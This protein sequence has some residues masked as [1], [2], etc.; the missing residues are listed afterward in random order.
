MM[1]LLILLVVITT[2]CRDRVLDGVLPPRD[3]SIDNTSGTLGIDGNSSPVADANTGAGGTGG[4]TGSG[5][6]GSNTDTGG[7]TGNGSN[8]DA[9]GSGGNTGSGGTG[10]VGIPWQWPNS[11]S[12][13][14]SDAWLPVHHE[15]VTGLA[16]KLLV[17][18]YNN[19][20]AQS[21]VFVY[22]LIDAIKAG[23]TYHGY[24]DP[25][26]YP[27]L[28]YSVDR[29]IDKSDL[30]APA[31]WTHKYSTLTPLS[32]SQTFDVGALFSSS[33][34]SVL[35]YRDTSN[36]GKLLDLCTLFERG[37]IHEVWIL[38]SSELTVGPYIRKQIYDANNVA[39]KGSFAS[40]LGVGCT[41]GVSCSVT[42]RV[43]VLDPTVGTV[44]CSLYNGATEIVDLRL[45]VPYLDRML[46]SFFNLD[47]DQRF[48]VKF[49]SWAD[50]CDPNGASCITYPSATE[51]TGSYSDGSTWR[52]SPLLQGCGTQDYP[53]NA[54]ARRD[55]TN[56]SQVASRCEHYGM[57]DGAS[58]A[59]TTDLYS[60]SKV[61]TLDSQYPG[62]GGG[63][64]VYW[65]QNLP[66]L[67]NATKL[68]GGKAMRNFW[69]FL[70][71]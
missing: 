41:T 70:F 52:I 42:T 26:A 38:A 13:A 20:P 53:P 19:Q 60:A 54:R 18:N 33:Y 15:Q 17:L 61:A 21:L 14:N 2:G 31:D 3:G 23:A 59:D 65:R 8:T 35:D 25:A 4:N 5:G 11:E 50:L 64:Q 34:A 16:P 57:A 37:L 40:C 56:T 27:F 43:V 29:F 28:L 9:A 10:G 67:F 63:W 68:D 32:N 51:A 49:K 46:T 12:A 1:R 44:G 48:G 62:C 55:Y 47:F 30:S 71:Y 6:N 36:G 69:T 7:S 45:Y 58:G 24:S 39:V 22:A 66:G